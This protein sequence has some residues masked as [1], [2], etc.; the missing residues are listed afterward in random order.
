MLTLKFRPAL[1]PLD[2]R[3]V[4]SAVLTAPA[5]PGQ[6]VISAPPAAHPAHGTG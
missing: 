1:E 3:V 4:P 2:I 5:G 6:V